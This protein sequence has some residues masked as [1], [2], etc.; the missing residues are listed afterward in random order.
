MFI[1]MAIQI[2]EG[3]DIA[4]GRL[5]LATLYEAIGDACDDY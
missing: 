4:L 5:L 2:H 3:Q 1:P